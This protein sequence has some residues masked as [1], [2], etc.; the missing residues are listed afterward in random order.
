[1]LKNNPTF[2]FFAS[3]KLAVILLV[4][5]FIILAIAS[6][7]EA[8]YDAET[9]NHMVYGHPLFAAFLI[10]LA[11]N[12]TASALIRY[13]WKPHQTGFVITHLG[14]LILLFGG[15]V[16]Y[17]WGVDGSVELEEGQTRGR[18]TLP[19]PVLY[20]G[21]QDSDVQLL[22]ASLR[23]NPP[24][25]SDPERIQLQD[26][27]FFDITRYFH[28]GIV[29]KD[30][31]SDQQGDPAFHLTVANQQ[32]QEDLWL[33]PS[34]NT[35]S[36]GPALFKLKMLPNQEAV[37]QF[38]APEAADKA[39]GSIQLLVQ[40]Q[41]YQFTIQELLDSPKG[42]PIGNEGLSLV[43]KRYLP[44]GVVK[45]NQLINA[46]EE[47]INPMAEVD[48]YWQ[49]KQDGPLQSWILLAKMPEMNTP[50]YLDPTYD[51]EIRLL[52][53]DGS[54]TQDTTTFTLGWSPN[55]QKAYYSVGEQRGAFDQ[56]VST[57]WMNLKVSLTKKIPHARI[58]KTVTQAP[59]QKQ[60]SGMQ[61]KSEGVPCVQGHFS[62]DYETEDFYLEQGEIIRV[63]GQENWSI[64]YGLKTVPL[65]FSLTLQDFKVEFNPGTKEA[66]SY[67]SIVTYQHKDEPP[68]PPQTIA[69]NHPLS[70]DGYKIFQ[71]SFGEVQGQAVISVL[72]VNRDPGLWLKY[73][74]SLI[75]VFGIAHYYTQ[76]P[77][78]LA[79]LKAKKEA[80]KAQKKQA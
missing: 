74:G 45:D 66:A 63:P 1:M 34:D 61:A 44:H 11:A 28:R 72:A 37:S 58:V 33:T 8:T 80:E 71:A 57:G 36:L 54:E 56:P 67:T 65:G 4:V 55:Q 22:P 24:S 39:L 16:T 31:I 2:R 62:G 26:N 53:L 79:K 21:V 23:F 3:L 78:E 30:F 10:L 69:M 60:K 40:D 59:K 51:T 18:V 15:L 41:P 64:G 73:L 49:E 75:L 68:S 43:L 25:S 5:F 14:I 27:L 13:P 77:K 20:F 50:T 38:L 76:R 12:I 46:S 47:P 29:K 7:V 52:L 9:A 17:F 70:V 48:I 35:V 19:E 32:V 42:V 6:Q